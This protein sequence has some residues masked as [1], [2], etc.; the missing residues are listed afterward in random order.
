M[1]KYRKTE[2]S[3]NPIRKI[4][5]FG[6]YSYG[7][8]FPKNLVKNLKWRERQKIVVRQKGKKLIIEDWKNK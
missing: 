2:Q 8:T 4:T 5:K 1:A 3:A 6:K 7:I